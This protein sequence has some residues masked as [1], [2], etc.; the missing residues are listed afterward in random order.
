MRYLI[1]C[2][3]LVFAFTTPH[4]KAAGLY[5]GIWT[6]IYANTLIG[7]LTIHENNGTI[8]VGALE[9]DYTW[10]ALMGQRSGIN[11]DVSSIA[12]G[13]AAHYVGAF[14]SSTT[15][16]ATQVSCVPV[17]PGYGCLLPNGANVSGYK[18]W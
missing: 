16:H 15:Y 17:S 8:L 18:I 2:A 1:A 7:Y 14:P 12:G 13:V 5:D 10:S 9:S 6:V 11:F 3:A 4:A